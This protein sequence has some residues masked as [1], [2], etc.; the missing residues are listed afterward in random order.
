MP[1]ELP[2]PLPR[3]STEEFKELDHR[4]MAH[5]FASHR[6]L[7]RL[8]D[9]TIYQADL[10][11]RLTAA[12]LGPVRREFPITASFRGFT[13]TYFADLVVADRALY[14][15]KTETTLASAHDAQLLNYLL[16]ANAARGKLVN[17]RPP[18]VESR[19]VN[20]PLD[21]A[22]RHRFTV[23]CD[24]PDPF[25]TLITELI[26]DFGTGLETARYIRTL[27]HLLGGEPEVVR[28]LPMTRGP[29]HLGNQRF[30]L[31]ASDTAFFLTSLPSI[32]TTHRTHLQR[33]L[34]SSPL[35]R[36]LWAN[37]ALHDLSFTTI[38]RTPSP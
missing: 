34:Q 13:H 3:L 28:Q 29:V 35:T 31:A 10:A 20:A 16:L 11:E 22:E 32:D 6:D 9:E 30:H 37:L 21:T 19:F 12:G 25:F 15:L 23:H 38:A 2:F 26:M 17:F 7:G 27:T 33:L 24:R 8:C 4:V 36:L 18:S 5:A 1:I 14:E